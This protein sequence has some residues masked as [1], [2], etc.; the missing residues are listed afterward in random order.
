MVGLKLI[1]VKLI[2][3][4]SGFYD[5]R[6]FCNFAYW[7]SLLVNS[8]SHLHS[9]GRTNKFKSTCDV[10]F[11]VANVFNITNPDGLPLATAECIQGLNDLVYWGPILYFNCRPSVVSQSTAQLEDLAKVSLNTVNMYI[12]YVY[13]YKGVCCLC[14]FVV[15]NV[16]VFHSWL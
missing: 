2:N 6:F 12:I 5:N 16:P 8:Y 13:I 7:K 1:H 10:L 9:R 14:T 15:H 3:I 4:S 11:I